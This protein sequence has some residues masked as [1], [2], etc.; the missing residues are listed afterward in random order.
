MARTTLPPAETTLAT[1]NHQAIAADTA[2]LTMLGTRAAEVA[3]RYGDGQPYDRNRVVSEARFFM[4]QSAE[5]MLE[6]GKRLVQIKENEPHGDFV[7]ILENRLGLAPR[8]ARVMMQAAVKYL[9]PEFLEKRQAPAVLS[10]GRAKLLDLLA[11]SDDDIQ[12]LAEGGTVA[13]LDLDDMQAM[14]TRELRA[15]LVESRKKAAAKDAVITKKDAKLNALIESEEMRRSAKPAERE[16]AQLAE[17][18]EAG[19]AAE[20]AMRQ[21]LAAAGRVMEGP[22][23]E[24]TATAARQAVEYVAQLLAGLIST[25]G[26]DV[27]FAE[28]VTPHWL[29]GMPNTASSAATQGA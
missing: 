2:A 13:G 12:A 1:L 16:A 25:V 4:S 11:E 9:A 8:T 18:Q 29:A 20:M 7:E 24:A 14:S 10:L 28:M 3:E 21:L 26:V 15:A 27:D 5:A 19:T 6:A 17:L 23:T 22:A